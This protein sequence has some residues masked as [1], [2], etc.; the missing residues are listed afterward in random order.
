[1][2][3]QIT[4]N[5][6][7]HISEHYVYIYIRIYVCSHF[8]TN[9][10]KNYRSRCLIA[11]YCPGP[12]L[13]FKDQELNQITHL[14]I[15]LWRD[16]PQ[17]AVD[18]VVQCNRMR[19]HAI[20]T[21]IQLKSSIHPSVHQ[22]KWPNSPSLGFARQLLVVEEDVTIELF[23][24]WKSVHSRIRSVWMPPGGMS[25]QLRA[26]RLITGDKAISS[27]LTKRLDTANIPESHRHFDF[28]LFFGPLSCTTCHDDQCEYQCASLCTQGHFSWPGKTGLFCTSATEVIRT[29]LASPGKRTKEIIQS[30]TIANVKF[31]G[32]PGAVRC[33]QGCTR[34]CI[35]NLC[36]L[37][38]RPCQPEKDSAPRLAFAA[39]PKPETVGEIISCTFPGST[40]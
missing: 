20:Q 34:R 36:A 9:T 17:Q 37:S 24:P 29:T 1:M 35:L 5:N 38:R 18:I 30:A 23:E 40:S 31:F 8:V 10:W 27:L 16:Q 3:T 28:N 15:V 2:C 33:D 22:P 26:L 32:P 6:T 7:T 21:M 11:A 4:Q 14:A 13:R 39:V 19:G 12:S 25:A